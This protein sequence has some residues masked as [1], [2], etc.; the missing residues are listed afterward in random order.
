VSAPPLRV[1]PEVAAAIAEQQPVVA[2]ES[3]IFSS[4]GLS[5]PVNR[6]TFDDCVAAVRAEG[7]VPALCAVLDGV[8]HVGLDDATPV[9]ELTTKLGE[10][11]L[12]IAIARG[13]SGVTTV[14]ATL[15]LAARAGIAVFATGGIGGVHRDAA[16]SGDISA[17]L[18]A[19]ARHPVVTVSAG[20]KGFLDVARTVEYLETA[21]VPVLG[22]QTDEFPAFWCRTS[23]ARVAARVEDAASVAAAVAAARA[24]GNPTGVLVVAPCPHGAAIAADEI[25]PVIEAALGAAAA[26][27]VR[28]GAVTPHLLEHIAVSTGGRALQA[29]RALAVHNA[30]IAAAIAGSLVEASL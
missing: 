18:P 30:Q 12:P 28:G 11:D 29:N 3:T 22:W 2:L 27:G 23:G 16:T 20:V 5:A 17:D 13:G 6:A 19:I 24:L 8:A 14:S 1:G 10:R 9:F 21:G 25:D 7:A 4:L 15:A 26:A